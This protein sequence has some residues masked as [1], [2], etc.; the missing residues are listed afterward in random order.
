MFEDALKSY[1]PANET[2][3]PLSPH[4]QRIEAVYTLM[5]QLDVILPM[6]RRIRRIKGLDNEHVVEAERMVTGALLHLA[7]VTVSPPVSGPVIRTPPPP[8]GPGPVPKL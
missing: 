6:F 5:G 3:P 1:K 7:Q 4:H 8:P 2:A